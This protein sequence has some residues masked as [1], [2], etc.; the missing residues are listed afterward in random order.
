MTATFRFNPEIDFREGI[1]EKDYESLTRGSRVKGQYYGEIFYGVITDY[2]YHN[3][4]HQIIYNV[5]L[6][7]PIMI[8][9]NTRDE[10]LLTVGVSTGMDDSGSYGPRNF[11]VPIK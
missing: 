1:S 8:F 7:H 2:R 6:D 11:L 10:I 9:G 5:K 3:M 4:S